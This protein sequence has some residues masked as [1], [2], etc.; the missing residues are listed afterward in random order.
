VAC[1]HALEYAVQAA[2][3]YKLPLAVVF[4]LTA[5]Y[6][7]ANLRH[8]VFMLEGLREVA[9]GLAERGIQF[10]LRHGSPPE[11]A[12][13]AG[14]EAAL[15][16]C[17][18]G[19]L[20]HQREWRCRVA[21][22]AGCRVVQVESDLIVPVRVTSDKAEYA[23]RTIRPKLHRRLDDYLK[24]LCTRKL[25]HSGQP[26]EGGGI[27]PQKIEDLLQPLKIDRGVAPVD[28]RVRGG[29]GEALKRFRRFLKKSLDSY[30]A[31]HNQPQTD[32][33]S[34]MSPHLHFGQVSALQL[35][36]ELR[37]AAGRE[38]DNAE[39]F[40]EELIVRRE[41]AANYV[42]F[43]P[44]YDRYDALPDW[45][46]KTLAEHAGDDRSPV[47][48]R[49]RLDAADTHDP[50]W[51]AAMKEMRYTGFM[52]NYMRMYWAKK[53]LE[54]SPTPERAFA[55]TLAFNNRYF[56]DGRD[57][58]SYTGVA[59]A[60]GLHDRPWKERA[61][62]GKVRYMAASGLERKCDIGAYVE[63]VD[64]RVAAVTL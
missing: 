18:R 29:T 61:V 64:R 33:T 57:A 25:A 23:A 45:A 15:I 4:G 37:A 28:D 17:D 10:V 5:D 8:Y 1:N 59:W 3:D 20:R 2:N 38:N 22:E 9:S 48:E 52:H 62:F 56:V 55:R 40:L 14:R 34:L 63:K 53:I 35:A 31:H 46:R 30:Q 47:Y 36:L 6:P 44:D 32:D 16:V 13:A 60:F 42:Y 51:N 26:L 49:E 41:L 27:D 21:R 24:P 50:Y 43:T 7:D 19:Y 58:N 12:L 39:A 54:W 11:T